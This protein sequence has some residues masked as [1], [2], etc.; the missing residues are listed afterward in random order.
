MCIRDRRS[1]VLDTQSRALPVQQAVDAVRRAIGAIALEDFTYVIKK[2]DSTLRGHIA[3]EVLAVDQIFGSDL[4]LC[5][6]ALPDLGRTTQQG[7]QHLHGVPLLQTEL[8]SCLLYTSR[9]VVG[10]NPTT[11]TTGT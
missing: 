8:R 4:V 5:M 10:S 9:S 2:V 11:A 6:P 1:Y 7:V 3:Q